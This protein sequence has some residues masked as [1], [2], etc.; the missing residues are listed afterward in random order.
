MLTLAL[1]T[2]SHAGLIVIEASGQMTTTFSTALNY[3]PKSTTISASIQFDVSPTGD[4]GADSTYSN[5]LGTF[6]WN[7]G[8]GRIFT[9]SGDARYGGGSRGNSPDNLILFFAGTGPTING[10]TPSSFSIGLLLPDSLSGVSSIGN[11]IQQSSVQGL[12]FRGTGYSCDNCAQG[13]LTSSIRE[14]PAPDTFAILLLGLGGLLL[15]SRT[16]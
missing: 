16:L 10:L 9:L 15:A 13:Q 1:T 3:I 4:P 5:A 2:P 11:R 14:V 8:T 12:G 7:D 6:T